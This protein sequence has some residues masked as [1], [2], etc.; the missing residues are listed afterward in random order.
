VPEHNRVQ[1]GRPDVPHMAPRY[2]DEKFHKS[3]YVEVNQN[4]HSASTS[5]TPIFQP[6]AIQLFR[7]PLPNCGTLRHRTSRQRRHLTFF[8]NGQRDPSL[9]SFFPKNPGITRT[10]TVISDTIIYLFIYLITPHHHA[11][12]S[13][14]ISIPL[15]S[16]LL[17]TKARILLLFS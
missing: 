10:V 14:T 15:W 5:S 2:L 8:R 7:L 17:H 6:S 4:L 11:L 9:Q 3:S 12:I 13:A 1:A 16:N